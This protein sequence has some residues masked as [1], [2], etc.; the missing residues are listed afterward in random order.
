MDLYF[1]IYAKCQEDK[2]ALIWTQINS[3]SI[4]T[5][6]TDSKFILESFKCILIWNMR[7]LKLLIS[8][9]LSS[10]IWFLHQ[11][12]FSF[13]LRFSSFQIASLVLWCECYMCFLILNYLIWSLEIC[14]LA[15][16]NWRL[17]CSFFFIYFLFIF[18]KC[19]L[20]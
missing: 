19:V 20:W 16:F 4:L 17:L 18:F 8:S 5:T 1:T 9:S 2:M 12:I 3:D 13:L 6:L 15:N 11:I 10:Y 7:W 14:Y